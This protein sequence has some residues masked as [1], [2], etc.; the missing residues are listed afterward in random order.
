MSDFTDVFC[1]VGAKDHLSDELLAEMLFYLN[2]TVRTHTTGTVHLLIDGY[3]DD[4][5]ELWEIP[6]ARDYLRRLHLELYPEVVN[7]LDE[8]SRIVGQVCCGLLRPIGKHPVTGNSLF[9]RVS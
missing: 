9:E 8:L 2:G 6:E 3:D 7:R 1:V 4:P 5:H